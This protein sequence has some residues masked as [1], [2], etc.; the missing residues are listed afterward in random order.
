MA[1]EGFHVHGPHEHAV[2]HASLYARYRARYPAE[3]FLV[4]GDPLAVIGMDVH[5]FFV[6]YDSR[7]QIETIAEG[8][9]A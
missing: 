1:S 9:A 4:N 7:L 8:V 3:C 5:G 2:E 6:I